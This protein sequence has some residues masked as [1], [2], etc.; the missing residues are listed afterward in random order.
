MTIENY[1]QIQNN[2]VINII[3]WDGNP[4]TW[5]PPEEATML[6]QAVTP[7]MIWMAIIEN[8]II[9]DWVLTEEIGQAD[10]GFTW[11]GTVCTTNQPKPTIP[12]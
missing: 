4:N 3:V 1:L 7:A 11:N 12:N 9:T 8:S 6:I 5:Q 2:E 10:I